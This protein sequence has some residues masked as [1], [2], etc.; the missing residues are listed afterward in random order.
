MA[1]DRRPA[2]RIEEALSALL[3]DDRVLVDRQGQW[4]SIVADPEAAR[5]ADRMPVKELASGEREAVDH[6]LV[7]EQF[8]DDIRR[9]ERH[10]G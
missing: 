6:M 2:L 3:L 9:R 10:G 4:P 7:Q 1:C 8:E 5:V